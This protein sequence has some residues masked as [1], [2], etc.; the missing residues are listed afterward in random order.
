MMLPRPVKALWDDLEAARGDVLREVEGLS[1]AQSDWRPGDREWSIGEVVDHLTVAEINTGKLT[2]RLTREAEATGGT[3]PFPADLEAFAALPPAPPGPAE[4]PS[5]VWPQRGKAIGELRAAMRAARERSRQSIER[6]G[7][8][9]PRPLVF[10]HGRLGDL[11]LAQWWV[12]QADHDRVHLEQIRA[13]KRTA[14][15]PSR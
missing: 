10:K 1:Q 11:D 13:I 7:T 12:L 8:L 9:D 15:F 4:A 2:T 5:I 6:L 14:G 3:R